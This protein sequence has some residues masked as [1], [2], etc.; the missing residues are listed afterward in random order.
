MDGDTYRQAVLTHKNRVFGYAVRLL[1][2]RDDARDVAQEALV[3]LW[4]HREKVPEGAAAR[5]WLLKT[6]HRLCVDRA[7]ASAWA[8]EPEQPDL[9]VDIAVDLAAHSPEARAS[10]RQLGDALAATLSA[11]APRD[12][13]ALLL[14]DVEGLSYEECAEVLEVPLGTLKA[15]LHR[16]RERARLRLTKAG[17]AP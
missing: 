17:V 13:A 12:R 9:A 3:R 4:E 2:D 16:A 14:R 11:L 5:A 7:R 8:V 15:I 10:T 1:G 6:A